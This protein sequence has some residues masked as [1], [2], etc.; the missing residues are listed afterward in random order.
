MTVEL[1]RL[2][3]ALRAELFKVVRR[4]MTYICLAAVAILAGL[5][6]L[7]LWLRLREG[8]GDRP[9]EVVT[10]IVFRSAVSFT[11]AVPYGLSVTRFFATLIAVV[12]A[13]TIMGNEF[14]WRTVSV[15]AGRGVRRWHFIFAKAAVSVGF[16]FMVLLIGLAA[17]VAASAWLTQVYGLSWGDADAARLG[18]L[19]AG[20]ARTSFVILPFVFLAMLFG[21]LWKSGGQ[22]VGATLGVFFSEQIFNGLLGLA[23]GWPREIPKALFSVNIDA[24]MRGNGLFANGGGPFVLESGGPPAW[25]GALVLLAWGSAFA[26]LTFWRFQRRDIHE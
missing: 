11:N 17:C 1:G 5:V 6:F 13:G 14:D 21:L 2:A 8:P 10:W 20:L 4:R 12:F 25:Q 19:L 3:D 9:E 23:S 18:S 22:A 16:T 24:V 15:V 7:G 26:A